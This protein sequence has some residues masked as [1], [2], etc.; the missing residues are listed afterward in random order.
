MAVT[1]I[2]ID[3]EALEKAKQLTG[4]QSNR[5]AVDF[6]LK[7]LIGKKAQAELIDWVLNEDIDWID[8]EETIDYPVRPQA[9]RQAA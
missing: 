1:S 9:G 7:V 3:P 4:A 8:P 5:E 2:D 6:A